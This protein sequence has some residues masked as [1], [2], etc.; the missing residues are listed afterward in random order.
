MLDLRKLEEKHDAALAAET[1]ESLTNWL[2][3][4]RLNAHFVLL[5]DGLIED[6]NLIAVQCINSKTPIFEISYIDFVPDQHD[7]AA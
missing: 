4:K 3:Q 1:S 2:N 5:G 7:I 6:L